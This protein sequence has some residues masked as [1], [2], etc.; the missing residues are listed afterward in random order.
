MG[1]DACPFREDV[2]PRLSSKFDPVVGPNLC[3]MNKTRLRVE[4]AELTVSYNAFHCI[5]GGSN[6][7]GTNCDLFTHKSSPSYLNHLVF[8]TLSAKS[9]G[10]RR[11]RKITKNACYLRHVCPSIRKISAAAGWALIDFKI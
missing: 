9:L 6:M 10:S 1:Y 2:S 7:T 4:S 5:Q 8:G 11:V 3:K